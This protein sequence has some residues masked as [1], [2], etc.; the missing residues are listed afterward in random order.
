M[1]VQMLMACFTLEAQES[2]VERGEHSW[3]D[4][5]FTRLKRPL[6]NDLNR[7]FV[8]EWLFSFGNSTAAEVEKSRA[9]ATRRERKSIAEG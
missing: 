1:N 8:P 9:V 4:R 5:I 7:F 2:E 3:V 6:G